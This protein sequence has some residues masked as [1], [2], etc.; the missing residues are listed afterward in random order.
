MEVICTL[1]FVFGGAK[2]YQASGTLIDDSN[3]VWVVDFTKFLLSHP[4]LDSNKVLYV[5]NGMCLYT[6]G[7]HGRN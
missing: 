2:I 7:K 1:V 4:E 3:E 6:G 5:D